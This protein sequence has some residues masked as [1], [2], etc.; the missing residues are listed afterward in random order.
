[1]AVSFLSVNTI[2]NCQIHWAVISLSIDVSTAWSVPWKDVLITL[3]WR[4]G[5]FIIQK[6]KRAF[7]LAANLPVLSWREASII[8]T[9]C[10]ENFCLT[11]TY[12]DMHCLAIFQ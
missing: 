8:R 10:S 12:T 4:Y 6:V 11:Q 5:F 1:M 7:S 3:K 9:D 2:G